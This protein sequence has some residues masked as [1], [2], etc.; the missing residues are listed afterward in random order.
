MLFDLQVAEIDGWTVLA[1]VG[2]LDLASA[3]QLR[4]EGMRLVSGGV[5][6]VVLDL[7]GVDFV[8]SMGL[9]VLVGLRKRLTAVGGALRVARPG[10]QAN[11]VLELTGL[12]LAVPIFATLDDALAPVVSDADGAGDA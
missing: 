10:D 3:P 4:Q 12:S 1:P 8:D 7:G 11:R 5:R 9:S 6:Q 2:E